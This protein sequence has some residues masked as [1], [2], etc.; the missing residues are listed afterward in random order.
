MFSKR[1]RY[2]SQSGFCAKI[3]AHMVSH[4]HRGAFIDDIE[5]FDYMLLF[6]MGIS[7]NAKGFISIQIIEKRLRTGRAAQTF[8]GIISKL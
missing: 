8:W 6:A 5:R 2:R 7:G 3:G 1:L 4:Q